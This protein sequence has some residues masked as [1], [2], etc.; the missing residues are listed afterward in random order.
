MTD[1]SFVV[2]TATTEPPRPQAAPPAP[3]LGAEV[4]SSLL[5]LALLVLVV[6]G[7]PLIVMLITLAGRL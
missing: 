4:R 5:L 7:T 3:A 6:A 2:G 1:S